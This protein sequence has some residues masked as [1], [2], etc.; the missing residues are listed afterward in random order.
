MNPA[1]ARA[2][3][4]P[5]QVNILPFVVITY[6]FTSFPVSSHPVMVET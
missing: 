4:I 6:Y 5:A 1:R 2:R 3:M